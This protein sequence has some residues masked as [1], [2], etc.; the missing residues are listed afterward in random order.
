MPSPGRGSWAGD[1]EGQNP[2]LHPGDSRSLNLPWR[3]TFNAAAGRA[4]RGHGWSAGAKRVARAAERGPVA[5]ASTQPLRWTRR[6][7]PDVR[8]SEKAPRTHRFS[9]IA[10]RGANG[11]VLGE[12]H[13]ARRLGACGERDGWRDRPHRAT[14]T[15]SRQLSCIH[16][17][18]E[19][20]VVHAASDALSSDKIH[21]QP[22]RFGLERRRRA[23]CQLRRITVRWRTTTLVS[24]NA[25]SAA[26][27]RGFA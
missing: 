13:S 21:E 11:T 5:P 12:R 23:P 7:K 24:S 18:T 25:V 2:T 15:R 6:K 19:P 27:Q 26:F 4:R 20:A 22:L 10:F 1:R 17:A 16:T 9:G 3:S 14:A 8:P